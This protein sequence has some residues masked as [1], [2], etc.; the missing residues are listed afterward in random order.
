[1]FHNFQTV[2]LI[3]HIRRILPNATLVWQNHLA[4]GDPTPVVWNFLVPLIDQAQVAVFHTLEYFPR[5][6]PNLTALHLPVL[7]HL[8]AL[9]PF[10]P[11]NCELANLGISVVKR[12]LAQYQRDYTLVSKFNLKPKVE[13]AYLKIT[14]S[15]ITDLQSESMLDSL[16][17]ASIRA[18]FIKEGRRPELERFMTQAAARPEG[19][20]HL[21]R[22]LHGI[23]P[24]RPLF[25]QISRFDSLKDPL[26]TI[27]AFVQAYLALARENLPLEQ[28]PQFVLGGTLEDDDLRGFEELVRIFIYLD[29]LQETVFHET[30]REKGLKLEELSRQLRRDV[31]V[32]LLPSHDPMADSLEINALQ[33]TA[34]AVIQKS[35]REGFGLAVTEAMWKGVPVIGGN[36]GG[37]RLQITHGTN[38]FLAGEWV[39]DELQDSLEDTA[40]FIITYTKHPEVAARMGE[41]A[42]RKVAKDFLLPENLNLFLQKLQ[43][44]LAKNAPASAPAPVK[45]RKRPAV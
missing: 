21:V 20:S 13:K 33:R 27:K 26:G 2:G 25:A 36:T 40:Q 42:K 37:I 43:I 28:L 22:E 8:P 38:G 7:E 24:K 11:K 15:R 34:R 31:F 29:N 19:L 32:L 16:T 44:L 5:E 35:L 3:P 9:Y 10:S 12:V 30:R 39:G 45:K 17:K 18:A 6:N 1:M 23:D 14:G 41:M 4:T